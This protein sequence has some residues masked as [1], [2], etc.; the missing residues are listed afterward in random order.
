MSK[1]N[2][3]GQNKENTELFKRCWKE[4]LG[5]KNESCCFNPTGLILDGKG[6]N[7][8]PVENVYGK[9][10][11][12][13]CYSCE[14]HF[15]QSVNKS[16]KDTMFNNRSRAKFRDPLLNMDREDF[17]DE[18]P[19]HEKLNNW[20]KWW[21]LRKEHIFRAFKNILSPHSNL[22]EVIHSNWISTKKVFLFMSVF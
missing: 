7:W 22:G 5:G 21:V 16:L 3:E 19:G 14:F 12:H 15:K 9:E 2:C 8:K 4:A 20:L 18:E 6:S 10:L 1:P 11:L 17:L 13:C